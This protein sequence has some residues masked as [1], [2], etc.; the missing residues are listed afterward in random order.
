MIYVCW[1]GADCEVWCG[2]VATQVQ[3]LCLL[4]NTCR[5]L[6]LQYGEFRTGFNG[7]K[8]D[9]RMVVWGLRYILENYV[10]R[11]WTVEDVERA[12]IFFRCASNYT[13][14][15][16]ARIWHICKCHAVTV[17]RGLQ[18]APAAAGLVAASVIM[19]CS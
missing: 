4:L 5:V 12:D 11:Q 18:A 13:Q 16:N 3:A 1:G 19:S 7:D 8:E 17:H 2:Q 10:M 6:V 14:S 9:T 15:M